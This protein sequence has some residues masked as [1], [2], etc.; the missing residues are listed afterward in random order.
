M[1]CGCIKK[2]KFDLDL[3]HLGCK[4]LTIEDQSEWME[5]D[6]YILPTTY[7]LII[8]ARSREARV[9]IPTNGKVKLTSVDLFNSTKSQCLPDDIY[10]F[11]VNTCGVRQKISR[12]FLCN[13]ECKI[14]ELTSK[15]DNSDDA[16][17]VS[18]YRGLAEQVKIAVKKGN[19]Q[20]AKEILKKLNEELKGLECGS[21]G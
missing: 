15:I 17:Q 14:D 6:S 7:E 18:K 16:K 8:T 3:N 1:S 21:C 5:G 11:E 12:A 19:T 13:V 10:C 9:N 2:G 20:T 4:T